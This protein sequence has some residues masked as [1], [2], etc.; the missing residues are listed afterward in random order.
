MSSL[1]SGWVR[2]SVRLSC[3]LYCCKPQLNHLLTFKFRILKNLPS[4]YTC[5][6][7]PIL[8][9]FFF[10]FKWVLVS[11]F[12]FSIALNL[13]YCQIWGRGEAVFS[14]GSQ[15]LCSFNQEM[16]M[17]ITVYPLEK[18]LVTIQ[19]K[20]QTRSSVWNSKSYSVLNLILWVIWLLFCVRKMESTH[21]AFV[22]HTKK[23]KSTYVWT[24]RWTSWY[25]FFFNGTLFSLENEWYFKVKNQSIVRDRNSIFQAKIR[26]WKTYPVNLKASQYLKTT[27]IKPWSLKLCIISTFGWSVYYLSEPL[28]SKWPMHDVTES[29]LS[30]SF[31]KIHVR[32]MNYSFEQS[33]K[34]PMMWFQ[35]IQWK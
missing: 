20:C 16:E 24:V 17:R 7:E 11:A 22:L 10:S 28:F 5:F 19:V 9:F 34:C 14:K 31:I 18:T 3:S 4:N 27:V 15:E 25:F 1:L 33:A 23:W 13:C 8:T 2:N 21:E 32:P 6:L 12:V 35:G 26:I 30:K 29:C